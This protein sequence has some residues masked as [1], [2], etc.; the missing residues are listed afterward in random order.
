MKLYVATR[1]PNP[2]RVTMFMAEKGIHDIES[3][4]V[5][6]HS[7]E[8]RSDA[9]M[10]MR[11]FAKVPALQ[12]GDGRVLSEARAICVYLEGLYPTP[13]LMGAGGT[14]RAFIEM[15]DRQDD[16]YLFASVANC[17][18]HTHPGLAELEVRQFADF[19]AAQGDRVL[20][21]AR[22][23]DVLLASRKFVT[24][25]RFTI[26][27]ITLL[28]ALDFAKGPMKFRPAEQGLQHMQAWRDRIAARPSASA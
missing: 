17:I 23:F 13:N 16:L 27:G 3:V 12:L 14:E 25:E 19:G 6:L 20:G 15:A 11:P 26:A 9:F 4:N 2:R 1:A 7:G 21:V 24:M 8:H 10:A 22:H 28:C 18:R 5:D